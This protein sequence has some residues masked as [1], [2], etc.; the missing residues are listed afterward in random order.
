MAKGRTAKAIDWQLVEKMLRSMNDGPEIAERLG[1]HTDTLYRACKKQHKMSFQDY[2]AS[3]YAS[4]R[5]LLRE[6]QINRAVGYKRKESKPFNTS[7]GVVF[8]DVIVWYEPSDPM[9]KWL[10]IQYLNQKD[11]QDVTLEIPDFVIVGDMDEDEDDDEEETD[12]D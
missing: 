12:S 4:T 1:V 3:M 9:L 10:G 8:H 11:K 5:Q 6:Q 2:A 7:E